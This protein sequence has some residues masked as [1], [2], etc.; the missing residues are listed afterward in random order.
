VGSDPT[1]RSVAISDNQEQ[2]V[3]NVNSNARF[4]DVTISGNQRDGVYNEVSSP[5]FTNSTISN[6]QGWGVYNFDGGNPILTD[7]RI[8]GN[9]AGVNSPSSGG[10]YSW[11]SNPVLRNVTIS[12]NASNGSGGGVLSEQSTI[13]LE[14]VTIADNDAMG[15]GGGMYNEDTIA[16]LLNVAIT[17]N[18]GDRG[19]GV[20]NFNSRVSFTNVLLAGNRAAPEGG[21]IHDTLGSETTFTNVTIVGNQAAVGGGLFTYVSTSQIRNSVI[22]GN[23]AGTGAQIALGESQGNPPSLLLFDHSLVQGINLAGERVGNLDG[24]NPANDPLFVAPVLPELSPTSQGDYRLQAGSPLINAGARLF[25]DETQDNVPDLNGDGDEQ[26][27]VDAS[28]LDGNLRVAGAEVD[29]GPYEAGSAT[30]VTV[31]EEGGATR[32]RPG[33]A[34]SYSIVLSRQPAANVVITAQASGALELSSD[35]VTFGPQA[36]MTITPST[37]NVPQR[38]TVRFADTGAIGSGQTTGRITHQVSSADPTYNEVAIPPV[39]VVITVPG[40]IVSVTYLPFVRR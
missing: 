4:T 7:V 18:R 21:G 26:D 27:V 23:N 6:N 25:L 19:G 12:G 35:G 36:N 11:Y 16:V 8:T 34:D 29:L 15:N 13:V 31:S 22:W 28:D 14:N 9:Q 2:G 24:S 3:Y 30:A 39:D 10:V 5:T 33:T 20:Y 1:F 37:W 17:G 32:V 40:E 38:I